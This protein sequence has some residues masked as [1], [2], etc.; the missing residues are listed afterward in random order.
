MKIN[1]KEG[2]FT[3]QYSVCIGSCHYGEYPVFRKFHCI[4]DDARAYLGVSV[5]F[6]P[7][8]ISD[9]IDDM[10]FK[11]AKRGYLK[12]ILKKRI[13]SGEIY[14]LFNLGKTKDPYTGATYLELSGTEEDFQKWIKYLGKYI[15]DE[16]PNVSGD[17]TFFDYYPDLLDTFAQVCYAF[18]KNDYCLNIL[19]TPTMHKH[20]WNRGAEF[21]ANDVLHKIKYHSGDTSE[22][23]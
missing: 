20:Y 15:V 9:T 7:G 22:R 11:K 4:T 10:G 1:K 17:D 12:R 5:L 16:A 19:E 6:D 18:D 21:E 14:D 3:G 2:P 8:D 13:E 23:S